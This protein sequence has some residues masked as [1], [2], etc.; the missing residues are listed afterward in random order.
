MVEEVSWTGISVMGDIWS[1][2]SEDKCVLKSVDSDCIQ[3]VC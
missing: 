2:H 3:R 1:K